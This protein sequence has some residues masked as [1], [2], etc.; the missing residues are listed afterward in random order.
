[1]VENQIISAMKK[2]LNEYESM[3]NAFAINYLNVFLIYP[4]TGTARIMKI[5]GY[6][7]QGFGDVN[8]TSNY[9][10]MLYSYIKDRVYAD[11]QRMLQKYLGLDNIVKELSTKEQ[12]ELSYRILEDRKLH[13]YSAHY[14]R[15]SKDGEELRIICGFR[16]IDDIVNQ[17]TKK[18][19]EGMNKAYEALANAFYSLHRADIKNNTYYEIKSS[20]HIKYSELSENN[21]FTSNINS[22][23]DYVCMPA[24]IDDVKAFIDIN[25]LEERMKDK[26]SISIEFIGKFAGWVRMSYI[27]EDCDEYGHLWH[28]LLLVEVIDEEKRKEESLRLLAERDQLSG[29]YNR[30]TGENK[31]KQYIENNQKG[32]FCLMDC[33]YFKS[34]ND[35]FGHEIGDKVILEISN[36]LKKNAR[37]EDVAMRLGGDEFAVFIP[38]IIEQSDAEENWKK[39]VNAFKNIHIKELED[40]SLSI[41]A[42]CSMYDGQS[43]DNFNTLYKKADDA[44]YIS[45]KTLG[46]KLTFM[47]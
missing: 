4:A 20:S 13:Y 30:C 42:G 5:D 26:N 7:T 24:F 15:V 45:K 25:T 22:V 47:K 23:M 36:I 28:V 17:E 39:M 12:F 29:L 1:M 46:Y 8:Y 6:K 18:K 35:N 9:E 3:F 33:D 40:Y 2:E 44:M 34:I 10:M 41:S 14:I 16:N 31:I 43:N 32:L 21:T 38:G 27:K 11:D 37:E 19:E